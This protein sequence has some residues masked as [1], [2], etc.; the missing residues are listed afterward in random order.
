MGQTG[1]S[2]CKAMRNG[3]NASMAGALRTSGRVVQNGVR[4]ESMQDHRGSAEFGM[5]RSD[6]R[7]C[8]S[9]IALAIGQGNGW[10]RVQEA[11]DQ[12]EGTEEKDG[13]RPG[14]YCTNPFPKAQGHTTLLE[15][16][17][18]SEGLFQKTYSKLET[19]ELS[20]STR[21]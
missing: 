7:V 18:V 20:V 2:M 14:A 5:K 10:E 11:G 6:L 15:L 1:K 16:G 8:I 21:R 19:L 13:A 17:F 9:R 12:A 4:R 3:K